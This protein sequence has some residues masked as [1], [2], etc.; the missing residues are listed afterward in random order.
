MTRGRK[1]KPSALR[2]LQGKAGHR[3]LNAMEPHPPA[4]M[5]PCPD[6][7]TRQPVALAKWNEKAPQ[8]YAAGILTALDGDALADYCMEYAHLVEC[9]EFVREN[10]STVTLRDDKGA[11]RW[12]QPVP[13]ETMRLKHLEKCRQFLVEFGMT[14]SSRTRIH[15]QPAEKQ[16]PTEEFLYGG[17]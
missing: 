9:E 11:V 15:A 5:P 3:P 17:K 2:L 7:V 4:A 8:L 14:P 12:I 1:P 13:Q 16:N 10:G 6:I